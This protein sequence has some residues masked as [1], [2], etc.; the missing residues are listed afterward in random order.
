MVLPLVP[1]PSP[2]QPFGFVV[3][4]T[5]PDADAAAALARILVGGRNAACV[6]V[7][8]G[9]T[10]FFRWQGELGWRDE[11]REES[12]VVML[13]KTDGDHL[14]E[15]IETIEREHPYECPEVI[16]LPIVA[17]ADSYLEWMRR[18]QA[19]DPEPPGSTS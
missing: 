19:T 12:E 8:P 18:S 2:V 16:A 9:A 11:I 10:S 5:A 15:L 4:C 3:L 14:P 13:I 17:G 7:L 6:N 1:T